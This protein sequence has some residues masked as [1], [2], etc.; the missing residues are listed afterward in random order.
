M[1]GDRL[2]PDD[3]GVRLEELLAQEELRVPD[4]RPAGPDNDSLPGDTAADPGAG[5]PDV[6]GDHLPDTPLFALLRIIEREVAVERIDRVW[7]FPPRHLEA[8]ET[9]VVVVAAYLEADN[10]RRRVFA[11]HYTAPADDTEPRL[12]LDE[13]GTAPAD[14]V[15]RV[16]EEVVER[17]KDEPAAPPRTVRIDS[18][19]ARWLRLIHDIAEQTLDEVVARQRSHRDPRRSRPGPGKNASRGGA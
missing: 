2:Q 1:S 13:F 16:V 15:G 3:P 6:E 19:P 10:D 4:E 14:R 11:A 9:A 8:G 5:E 18:D 7:I 12:A 17:L